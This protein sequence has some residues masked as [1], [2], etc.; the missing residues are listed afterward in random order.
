MKIIVL[1]GLDRSLS[2]FRGPLMRAM[3]AAGHEVVACAPFESMGIADELAEIGV[4]F[5][6]VALS[7]AG[8]NPLADVR[9]RRMLRSIFLRERPDVVLAYT[10]KPIVHGIPV[11]KRA[12]VRHCYALITGLGAAFNTSGLKGR[13]LQVIAA[14]LYSR[15]LRACKLIMVQNSGIAD[16]FS[17]LGITTATSSV[18]I[19]AGSGVDTERFVAQPLPDGPPVFLLLARM[20]RDKGIEE[21]V[22][23]ARIVKSEIPRAKFLLVGDA[24]PNP[25]AISP[26]Q[27]QKWTREAVVEYH[28]AVADVRPLLARCTVYVLPS[29][30]EGMPRSVLEAMA[31]ARPIITTDTIGCRETISMAGAADH[32]DIRTGEN[33]LLVPVRSIGP[34]ASAMLRLVKYPGLSM[35]MGRKGREIAEQQFDVRL[36][37]GRMLHAMDLAG[38]EN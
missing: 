16:R 11:A 9:Y 5:V 33:G 31:T 3:I 27:L 30:H 17:D 28:V 32:E 10:I 2:N 23:A 25:A 4:R 34:L 6:P 8:L 13:M 26:E 15:A 18:M 22:A 12:G 24:D 29:Y 38:R 37:N 14:K 35:Q 19:I 20:L 21:F 36:I 1:A 7:R